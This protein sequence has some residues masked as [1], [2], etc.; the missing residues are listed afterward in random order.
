MIDT[1]SVNDVDTGKLY[2]KSSSAYTYIVDLSGAQGIQGPKGDKG[3][4]GIQGPQVF[5]V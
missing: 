3:D 2:C 1:G 4:Q 5:R